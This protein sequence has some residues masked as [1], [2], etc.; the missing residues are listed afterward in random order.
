V[1]L[2]LSTA[3]VGRLALS[4][5]V[6]LEYL[7]HG[8]PN[9]VPVLLLHGVTDSWRSFEHVLPHLPPSIRAIALTQRGHGDSS[10]PASYH[11]GEMAGD[12]AAFM[13]ALRIP[14]AVIVGHSMGGQI[15]MRVALDHPARTR[16]LVLLGAFHTL[17]GHEVVQELWDTAVG[18]MRDPIDPAFVR[19]F[20]DGTVATPIAKVH[21]DTF[22]AQSLKVPARVWQATFREFLDA[23]IGHLGQIAVPTLVVTGGKDP[24]SRAQERL[25][26]LG[27]IRGAVALDYPELGHALHWERPA[28]IAGDI[29]RFVSQLPARPASADRH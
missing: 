23:E 4:T 9:G 20:Q 10:R 17:R 19:A 28:A 13:D 1:N 6:T 15:A 16:G 14:S 12:V 7:E 26:L 29:A 25:A 3:T 21:L 24:L 2:A 8:N 27:A 18:A 11:Y 5:G 22:V